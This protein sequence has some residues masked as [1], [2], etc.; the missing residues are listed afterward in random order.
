MV[1][2][3]LALGLL[4]CR[5][6]AAESGRKVASQGCHKLIEEQCCQ[7]KDGRSKWASNC[8]LTKNV[9]APSRDKSNVCQPE[10]FVRPKEFGLGSTGF[11]G[12]VVD[13]RIDAKPATPPKPTTPPCLCV[14]DIDRTLTGRQ[15]DTKRCKS[16]SVIRGVHDEAYGGGTLTLSILARNIGKTFCNECY[17]GVVSAGGATGSGSEERKLLK[18]LLTLTSKGPVL[19]HAEWNPSG[20]SVEKSP[21]VTKCGDGRKQTAIPGILEWYRENVGVSIADERVYMFDDKSSNIKG[22]YGT[23][24]NARQISCASRYKDRGVCGATLSEIE[25]I[26]GVSRCSCTAGS[27][28]NLGGS[29]CSPSKPCGPYHGD[30]D[31]DRDCA[32]DLVCVPDK[33]TGR[34]SG[35]HEADYCRPESE[36]W[37]KLSWKPAEFTGKPRDCQDIK[38]K[39][40][41]TACPSKIYTTCPTILAN[42]YGRRAELILEDDGEEYC[43]FLSCRVKCKATILNYGC[44]CNRPKPINGK[45]YDDKTEMTFRGHRRMEESDD[46]MSSNVTDELEFSRGQLVD[47]SAMIPPS[48][49]EGGM[50][51]PSPEA[52]EI[53]SQP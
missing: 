4:L 26:A 29:S 25:P 50:V 6:T 44:G 24:Y 45:C 37:R 3:M 42:Y 12:D 30:C 21:L 13:C 19:E 48:P 9:K 52:T 51:A 18:D 22:F 31:S 41:C 27:P 34:L 17:L 5:W 33:K 7:Y 10:K 53:E 11:V 20:C 32:G 36:D 23:R 43:G 38:V 15:G 28:C 16:N 40:K 47:P 1:S 35:G 8:V 39:T 14:F 46:E 49:E 2:K